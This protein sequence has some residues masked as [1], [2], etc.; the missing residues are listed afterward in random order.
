MWCEDLLRDSPISAVFHVTVSVDVLRVG[1][2]L[3][4]WMW[5]WMFEGR[6]S[7]VALRWPQ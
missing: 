6:K 7:E 3:W 4:M 5:M 1:C 2:W